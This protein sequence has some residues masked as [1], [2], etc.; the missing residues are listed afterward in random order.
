MVIFRSNVNVVL[1]IVYN[2][3]DSFYYVFTPL[4]VHF[5]E[6]ERLIGFCL[7]CM[8]NNFEFCQIQKH[9]KPWKLLTVKPFNV[10]HV[11][12]LN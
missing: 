4:K 10:S 1:N 8:D 12:S 6:C 3:L 5:D 2:F 11:F 9:V 7:E